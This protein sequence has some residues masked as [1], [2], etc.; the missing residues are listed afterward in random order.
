MGLA[1]YG[2]PAL[3]RRRCARSCGCSEDGTLRARPR[4][5]PPPPREDRLRSG[6]AA[7]RTSAR[8]SR[9]RSRS[10]SGPRAQPDEPLDAAPPRHRALGA[11]DVR[12]GV[13]PS[14]RR[15]CTRSIGL[16]S[17]ALAGGCAMNS[18][19][20]GKVLR[21]DA[22]QA[23]LRAGGGRRCGRRDRRGD[24]RLARALDARDA[25]G[26][27]AA[28][29][30]ADRHGPR[31]SGAGSSTTR[32]SRRCSTTHAARARTARAARVERIADED[33]LCRRTAAA[34]ADGSV[35]GWFQGRMEWGPRALGNR[36]ILCDPRRADM[37][38]ILNAK[39]KRRESLPP[40]RA[41]G[42]ARSTSPSGSR[43][44]TTSRS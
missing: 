26:A 32:R 39:I 34:I 31:L 7:A 6:T 22:V 24:A 23:P 25:S 1:P 13:L 35:V 10:C 30:Q 28:T 15:I 36:S 27:L 11:G 43:R 4:L 16:D 3:P 2:E 12:G 8:C 38:D 44:T 9:R 41:V 20:N 17:L 33:E 5:L 14:A 29:L 37:K 18:V 42:P 19:A 40:V 21:A